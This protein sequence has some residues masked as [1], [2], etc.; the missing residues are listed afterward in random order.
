MGQAVKN[1]SAVQ[2]TWLWSLGQED[3][4]KKGLATC[5][6]VPAWKTAW[7]EEPGGLHIVHRVT[8]SQTRLSDQCFHFLIKQVKFISM[9]KQ[10]T[11]KGKEKIYFKKLKDLILFLKDWY[12]KICMVKGGDEIMRFSITEV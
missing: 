10:S 9:H 8:K 11:M 12:T 1:L 5:S 7:T 4:L 2:E 3:P 6:S